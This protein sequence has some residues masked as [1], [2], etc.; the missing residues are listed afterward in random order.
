M[1][2]DPKAMLLPRAAW[3][4]SYSAKEAKAWIAAMDAAEGALFEAGLVD[5]WGRAVATVDDLWWLL[6]NCS[7]MHGQDCPVRDGCVCGVSAR[8]D[9]IIDRAA[10]AYHVREACLDCAKNPGCCDTH[11]VNPHG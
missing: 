11:D 1:V 7:P 4:D 2:T 3:P 8:Y 10:R 9:A 5:E 6:D